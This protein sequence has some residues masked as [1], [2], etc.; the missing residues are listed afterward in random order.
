MDVLKLDNNFG[1]R[2]YK[3]SKKNLDENNVIFKNV[4]NKTK[5]KCCPFCGSKKFHNHNNYKILL[6]NSVFYNKIEYLNI[7]Y[8]RYKC[9]KCHKTFLENIE[10]RYKNTK[11]TKNLTQQIIE[12][13]KNHQI[14][15]YC[16]EKFK[17][18]NVLVKKIIKE[19]LIKENSK[20]DKIDVKKLS[21]DEKILFGKRNFYTIFRD[22][23]TKKIN[24]VKGTKSDIVEKFSKFF[25]E[26]SKKIEAVSIDKSLSFISGVE[27]FLPKSKIVL[28]Y[29]HIVKFKF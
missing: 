21:I 6:K 24:I 3:E 15:S 5:T 7:N 22:Y 27:K 4:K 26:K 23:D 18:S 20:N 10:N 29:F 9:K 13:F 25:V 8:H 11:I 28:D 1:K 14:M 12:D 16:A 17:I 19:F 2:N